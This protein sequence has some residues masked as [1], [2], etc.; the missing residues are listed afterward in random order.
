MRV[1]NKTTMDERC[2][3]SAQQ[4]DVTAE[5]LQNEEQDSPHKVCCHPSQ[6]EAK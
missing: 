1:P 5:A 3:E 2:D 4:P 6:V